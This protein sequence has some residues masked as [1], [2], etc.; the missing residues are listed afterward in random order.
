[1]AN[2]GNEFDQ[3]KSW[4]TRHVVAAAAIAGVVGLL[5]GALAF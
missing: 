3:V 1:M 2:F 5:I 4:A